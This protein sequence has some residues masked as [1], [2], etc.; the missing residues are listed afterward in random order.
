VTRAM[1][2]AVPGAQQD[3]LDAAFD[4]LLR[5]G[6]VL[7]AVAAGKHDVVVA[8][9]PQPTCIGFSESRW[10]LPVVPPASGCYCRSHRAPAFTDRQVDGGQKRRCI[11]IW[12]MGKTR[13]KIPRAVQDA[14]MKEFHHKCAICGRHEP[15]FHHLNENPSDNRAENLLPLCPNH[16]LTDQH[17]PTAP[18]DPALLALFRQ[19]KDPAILT[20]QFQPLFARTR[21]LDRVEAM[22]DLTALKNAIRELVAFVRVLELGE[23]Y[24]ARISDLLPEPAPSEVLA[25]GA[26]HAEVARQQAIDSLNYRTNLG[27]A[28]PK[29]IELIVELLR[30]QNWT[31]PNRKPRA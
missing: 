13:G 6:A 23:F 3:I 5:T 19:F 4:V 30:F 12:P 24:A 28:R 7:D 27:A 22:G 1:A 17:N 10:G 20:P 21:F 9:K 31:A 25:F 14:V 16:H 26:P 8:A 18:V 29:V 2:V 15:Q 11:T